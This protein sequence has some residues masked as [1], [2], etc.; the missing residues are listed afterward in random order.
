M[1][2]YTNT[3]KGPV[4]SSFAGKSTEKQLSVKPVYSWCIHALQCIQADIIGT[5]NA[6]S[7]ELSRI[8][9]A[10]KPT[11]QPRALTDS[12]TNCPWHALGKGAPT[13]VHPT[14]HLPHLLGRAMESISEQ[15]SHRTVLLKS[16]GAGKCCHTSGQISEE[17][18]PHH[19][20]PHFA[21]PWGTDI[22]PPLPSPCFVRPLQSCR[23]AT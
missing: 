14:Q 5:E 1:R 10:P 13:C 17:S 3:T 18:A 16:A 23:T 12:L 15:W 4:S 2:C 7:I 6:S 9:P 8:W 22:S 19:A 20:G 11:V 21:I